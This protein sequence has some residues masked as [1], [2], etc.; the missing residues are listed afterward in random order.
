MRTFTIILL[1]MT[2]LAGCNEKQPLNVLVIAGGH[3]YDTLAFHSIFDNMK[4][5]RA[6]TIMQPEANR[7]I[8]AGLVDDFDVLV[9][10]DS[11]QEISE[12]E[13]QGYHNLLEKGTGMVF[14]HHALA[15]YQ[16]WPEFTGII[17]GKYHYPRH[18]ANTQYHSDYRHD[19]QMH[20]VTNPE[21]PITADIGDFELFDEGYMN[22]TYLSTFTPIM[23]T[24]HEHS[25]EII[26]WAHRVNN[27]NVVY[28][29]PGHAAPAF[30]NQAYLRIIRNA[31]WW[32]AQRD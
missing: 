11:W 16:E 22:L 8:G 28:L 15:S 10:Y 31:I 14:M 30:E 1:I 24:Y 7:Q 26:G 13:K 6:E 32:A 19:I 21:H 5:I 27:S 17:G 23:E 9:F 3:D 29:M 12:E 2:S 4:G 25:D 18:E 20:V